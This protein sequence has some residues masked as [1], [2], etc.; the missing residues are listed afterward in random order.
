MTMSQEIKV[1]FVLG[2]GGVLGAHEVGMLRALAERGIVPDAV[3]GTSI[4]AVNGAVF[5]ADP[6]PTGVQQLT[7]LWLESNLADVTVGGLLRRAGTLARSGTHVQSLGEVRDRLERALPVKRIEDLALPF[8][9]VAASIER[10]AE[11]WFDRGPL[12]EAVLASCAVPGVLPPV[13]IGDEHFIDGGIVNS[14][15]VARAVALGAREIYVLQVGRVETALAPPRWPWEVGLVAFE[16]ARRHRFAHDLQ[17][18]PEGI[19]L[20]VLPTGGSAAPAYNDIS[21]QLRYRRI[22]RTVHSQIEAAYQASRSYLTDQ[23]SSGARS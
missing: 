6:T 13:R 8:Q 16:V 2:G 1:A 21:A 4:G 9:C 23:R 14:I 22:A 10:A 11:H 12:A 7:R 19:T 5:A 15:P 18:L 3:L 20:H 17:A